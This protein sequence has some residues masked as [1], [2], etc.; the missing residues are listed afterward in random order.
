MAE[1]IT[2]H[3]SIGIDAPTKEALGKIKAEGYSINKLMR[4]LIIEFATT[5]IAKKG[6]VATTTEVEQNGK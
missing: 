6:G 1:F 3:I 5:G 4:K 2:G